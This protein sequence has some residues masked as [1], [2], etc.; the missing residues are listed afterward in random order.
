MKFN[1]LHIFRLLS[2]NRQE[3]FLSFSHILGFNPGNIE[4]YEIA[5]RHRS[6][7]FKNKNG[8]AVNNERLEFL[9]DAVLYSIISDIL[10]HR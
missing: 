6:V 7:P 1:P 2:K 5:V 8:E 10:Y 9:G 3:P 4:L